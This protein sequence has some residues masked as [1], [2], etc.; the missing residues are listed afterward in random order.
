MDW[1]RDCSCRWGLLLLLWSAKSDPG[2]EAG[3]TSGTYHICSQKTI[4]GQGRAVC[5]GIQ[6]QWGRMGPA[7]GA[8][9]AAEPGLN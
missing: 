5:A 1:I 4:Q 2:S 8:L 7:V 3:P 6:R 9:D